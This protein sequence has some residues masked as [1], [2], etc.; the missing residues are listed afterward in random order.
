MKI[1]TTLWYCKSLKKTGKPIIIQKN[2]KSRTSNRFELN[3]FDRDGK[4][5]K[6]KMNFKNSTGKAKKQGATTVLQVWK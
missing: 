5:V 2:G 6:I 4:P 3:L 1:D